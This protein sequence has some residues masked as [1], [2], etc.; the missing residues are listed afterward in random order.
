MSH[1]N[2]PAT[3]LLATNCACCGRALVDAV[4]VETGIGPECRKRFSVD[5]VVDE[6]AR[7]EAN[8]LVHSVAKRGV[9]RDECRKICEKLSA[10]G[11]VVLAARIMK[12]FRMTLEVKPVVDV[13]ALRAEYKAIITDFTYDNI[14]AAGFNDLVKAT[15]ACSPEE[16]VNAAK[17]M[18][19]KC[20]RCAGTGRYVVGSENGSPKFG[21]GDCFRCAGNGFQT[22]ED[23]IRNRAYDSY[24]AS[25]RV[26]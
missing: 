5:V 3:K 10:L 7:A 4:S 16:F 24:A 1:E 11:F 6:T 12:R 20:R 21:G 15:G 13:S 19:C 14:S 25:L 26:A 22:R 2:A 8:V 23:A 9:R 18:T 17:A